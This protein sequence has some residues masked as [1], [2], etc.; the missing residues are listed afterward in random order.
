LFEGQDRVKK[1]EEQSLASVLKL[2]LDKREFKNPY[3]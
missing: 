3:H 2:A 1:Y